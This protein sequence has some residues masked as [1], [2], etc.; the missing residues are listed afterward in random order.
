MFV[1]DIFIDNMYYGFIIRSGVAKGKLVAIDCPN[2]PSRYSIFKSCDI[3]GVNALAGSSFPVLA[4]DSVEYIGQPLAVLAGPDYSVLEELACKCKI[5]IEEETPIFDVESPN[6]EIFAE[7]ILQFDSGS[8]KNHVKKNEK[9][10]SDSVE[11]KEAEVQHTDFEGK[12]ADV[13]GMIIIDRGSYT[14]SVQEHWTSEP[15]GALVCYNEED[16]GITV[17]TST[18]WVEHVSKS[19]AEFLGIEH[20]LVKVEEADLGITLDGKIW[21]PSLISAI[22]ALCAYKT[23]KNIKLMCSREDDFFYSPKRVQ[24]KINYH[25]IVSIEEYISQTSI[26]VFADLG[27]A[28]FFAQ[29]ILEEICDA[30]MGDLKFG[31]ITIEAFAVKTNLPPCGAFAGFA[32]SQGRLALERHLCVI[33]DF[34]KENGF[35]FRKKFFQNKKRRAMSLETLAGELDVINALFDS[36]TKKCDYKRKWAAYEMLR[37]IEKENDEKINPMRG[38]G[39]SFCRL[40]KLKTFSF[41]V[42]QNPVLPV[43][44][45]KCGGTNSVNNI[46]CAACIVEI[47]IDSTDYEPVITGVWFEI[48]SEKT[49]D[50]KQA[51]YKILRSLTPA[52]GWAAGEG[53][54]YVD[55]KIDCGLCTANHIQCVQDIQNMNISFY[56]QDNNGNGTESKNQLYNYEELPFSLFTPAFIQAVSQAVNFHFTKNPVSSY[57]IWQILNKQ[58]E[59]GEEKTIAGKEK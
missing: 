15:A 33:S 39:M 12:P 56:E 9:E 41:D 52:L 35:D 16:G 31:N 46:P 25:T 44:T 28:D 55:G 14:T 50:K 53:L 51:E 30:V 54:K 57:D 40:N 11:Q 27:A 7:K 34:F 47:E 5:I 45:E 18:Q 38:I 6:A 4:S 3:T 58:H 23:K 22:A 43:L 59:S 37:H 29:E 2:L 10:M 36:I 17:H 32:A 49:E 1:N 8:A 42:T 48:F 26:K 24:V 20:S 13:D 19:C 21:Y